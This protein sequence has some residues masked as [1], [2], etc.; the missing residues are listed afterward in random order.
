M[1]RARLEAA[2]SIC[3]SSSARDCQLFHPS[4]AKSIAQTVK[5]KAAVRKEIEAL[6]NIEYQQH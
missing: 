1:A 2:T 5:T 6:V 4:I 3:L